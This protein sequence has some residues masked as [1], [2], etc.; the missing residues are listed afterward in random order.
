MIS[1]AQSNY[2]AARQSIYLF[3]TWP[4]WHG[5]DKS[6]AIVVVGFIRTRSLGVYDWMAIVGGGGN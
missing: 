4:A 6:F 3:I 2:Q 1:A 5:H